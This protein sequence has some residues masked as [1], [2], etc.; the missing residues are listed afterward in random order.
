[1]LVYPLA[2][3]NSG[4]DG[5][6]AVATRMER[7]CRDWLCRNANDAQGIIDT[8]ALKEYTFLRMRKQVSASSDTNTDEETLI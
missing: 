4:D 6:S 7:S 3:I 5:G 1:M 2:R 8:D